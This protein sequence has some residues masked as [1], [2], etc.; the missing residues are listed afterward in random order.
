M[1]IIDKDRFLALF[2]TL[3]P[4]GH[5]PFA[6]GTVGTLACVPFVWMLGALNAHWTF[7]LTLTLVVIVI[8]TI[9]S[10]KAEEILGKK[11]PSSVVIDE[12]AGYMV[13]MALLPA[14]VGYLIAGFFLFRFFDIVKPPP[15]RSLERLGGGPGIMA[16]DLLAGIITSA[17]L[18]AWRL[19]GQIG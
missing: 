19:M 9:A 12:F 11:D 16:D 5:V 14:T 17:I 8:G 4:V 1:P 7:Y 13:A 2:A 18:H 3:G 15:I 6:P 10:S